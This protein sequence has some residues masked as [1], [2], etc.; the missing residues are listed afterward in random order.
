[1]DQA[2]AIVGISKF[3]NSQIKFTSREMEV[4]LCV[5]DV[6]KQLRLRK[7]LST[8]NSATKTTVKV[9][10][11]KDRRS[12][13]KNQSVQKVMNKQSS[14]IFHQHTTLL[15]VWIVTLVKWQSRF[16]MDSSIV[17]GARKIYAFN[18]TRRNNLKS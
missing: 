17:L 15:M 7:V 2:R 10:L 18:A 3:L 14:L 13:D 12:K 11:L 8:A 4:L 5:I 9:V 16:V 1:M 6:E